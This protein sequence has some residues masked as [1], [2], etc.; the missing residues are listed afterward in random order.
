MVK[1]NL[2]ERKP[3]S[4]SPVQTVPTLGI[5]E[6]LSAGL[7]AVLRHPWLLLI[8]VV[9]DLFLWLGPRLQAPQLFREVEPTLRQM[10]T[11]MTTSEARYAVQELSKA[12]DQFFTQFN[13]FAWLSV[14]LIG[15]PVV[16][17]G[18]DAT[19]KLVTGSQP[20]M[21]QVNGFNGY[22]AMFVLLTSMGLLVA[23][24]YWTLLGDFVR[25]DLF[26]WQ[27]WLRRSLSLWKKLLILMIVVI[28]LIFM[29]IFPLSMMMF[30]LG[31]FSA[32]L[33]SLIPLL[34]VAVAAWI[35]L[36]CVFTPHG[37]VL[38]HMSLSRAIN[39]S[40]LIVRAN[41][42]PTAGL[43]VIAM[44]VSVGMGLIWEWLAADSWLRLIAIAGS[45]IVS[46]GLIVASLLFYRNRVTILFESHHWPLPAG[47]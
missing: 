44:A 30:M 25:G 38:H 27:R 11:Q 5:I 1:Y 9:L 33:A 10:T 35:I 32:G 43:V 8:P 16:N 37:L 3:G 47:R 39:T 19:L 17:G 12:V 13:L 29:S 45:A 36:V 24:L 7:D 20:L 6:A 42:G 18:I 2:V 41:F 4:P 34:A 46:T 15:V 22:L 23:A 21:W 26:H 40:N 28:S 14:T 31:V